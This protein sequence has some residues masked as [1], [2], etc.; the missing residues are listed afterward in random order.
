MDT[1]RVSSLNDI[2]RSRLATVSL[3]SPLLQ[4]ARRL[5]D[6]QIGLVVVCSPDGAIAGVIGK[7]DIVRQIGHCMGSACHTL[8]SELMT[9]E[10]ISC[11]PTDLFSDVLALMQ[12]HGLVHLPVL[13]SDRRP[14][15]V[16]NARDALRA[17]VDQGQYEQLQLFDYVMG[18][19]Y[20]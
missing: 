9:T 10:V 6:T 3:E 17:L 4:A 15:G 13:D 16:L 18:V 12:K 11:Q 20:H 1:L 8:V 19:G 5:S 7:S 2:A 14:I